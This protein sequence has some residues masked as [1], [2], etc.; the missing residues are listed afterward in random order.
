MIIG[1]QISWQLILLSTSVNPSTPNAIVSLPCL[2][3]LTLPPHED[4]DEDVQ[5]RLVGNSGASSIFQPGLEATL[6]DDVNLCGLAEGTPWCPF[7]YASRH[8]SV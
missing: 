5:Q 3:S 4:D 1:Y 8:C 7:H 2:P 6:P